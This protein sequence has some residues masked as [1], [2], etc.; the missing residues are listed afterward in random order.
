LLSSK[1]W[2]RSNLIKDIG[3][4]KWLSLTKSGV[5]CKY[6]TKYECSIDSLKMEWLDREVS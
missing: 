2:V 5:S 3:L 4:I 6:I 1:I